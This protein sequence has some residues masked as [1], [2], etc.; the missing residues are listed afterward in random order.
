MVRPY[1][2]FNRQ[3][4]SKTSGVSSIGCIAFFGN[5]EVLPPII[6][7][8]NFTR[9]KIS[10]AEDMSTSIVTFQSNVA[11]IEWEARAG[12]EGLGQGLLVGSGTTLSA[13]TDQTFD[14]VN[15]ELTN[16]DIAYR[17]TIYGQN[18]EGTWSG[19]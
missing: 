7:I 13:S 2:R 18:T 12:G 1:N 9:S 8:V 6:N 14:I 17:I 16:G 15:T 3:L 19:Y 10:A 4:L 11:L 5:T